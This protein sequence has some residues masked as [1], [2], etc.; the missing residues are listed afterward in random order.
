MK[1]S[2]CVSTGPS[3]D[4]FDVSILGGVGPIYSHD[5]VSGFAAVDNLIVTD[6]AKITEIMAT[7]YKTNYYTTTD[8]YK[9]LPE[10]EYLHELSPLPQRG[11]RQQDMPHNWSP[12]AL[13]VLL[14]SQQNSS[15][16]FMLGYEQIGMDSQVAELMGSTQ[17]APN[18]SYLTYQLARVYE[19]FPNTQFIMIQSETSVLLPSWS[20]YVNLTTDSFA[21]LQQFLDNF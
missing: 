17:E 21:S 5:I 16:V 12:A 20:N 4:S 7:G 19:W 6:A 9:K 1:I 18:N 14:A 13:A 10:S 15:L 8:I 11:K 2:F 3:L